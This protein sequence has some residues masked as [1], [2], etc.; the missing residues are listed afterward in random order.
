M[1]YRIAVRY[2]LWQTDFQTARLFKL[3]LIKQSKICIWKIFCLLPTIC[4]E[5]V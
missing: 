3:L 1:P 4:L 2:F 5:A